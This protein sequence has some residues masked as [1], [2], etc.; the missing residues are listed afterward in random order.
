MT[1][2]RCADER[3]QVL[4]GTNVKDLDDVEDDGEDEVRQT[5]DEAEKERR[6]V[7]EVI[8]A[9]ATRSQAVVAADGGRVGA[10]LRASGEAVDDAAERHGAVVLLVNDGESGEEREES[11]RLHDA[12]LHLVASLRLQ[13][14]QHHKCAFQV[15]IG[16]NEVRN[17]N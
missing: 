14:K 7:G 15:T 5:D 16:R 10:V 3:A 6:I 4:V 1:L 17:V 13:Q 11:G 12:P 2:T 8:R 9:H